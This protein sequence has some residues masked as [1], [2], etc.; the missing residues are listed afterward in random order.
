MK[1]L[2]SLLLLLH[3]PF[4]RL[5]NIHV[6]YDFRKDIHLNMMFIQEY[7]KKNWIFFGYQV[8]FILLFSYARIYNKVL[9]VIIRSPAPWQGLGKLK[10]R[11]Y[12]P[13]KFY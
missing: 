1:L 7:N 11:L 8:S 2:F 10:N 4:L 12:V 9:I 6:V 13:W 3:V 5:E